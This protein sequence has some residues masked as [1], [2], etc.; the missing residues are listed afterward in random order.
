MCIQDGVQSHSARITSENLRTVEMVFFKMASL[1]FEPY[2]S[3]ESLEQRVRFSPVEFFCWPSNDVADFEGS[4]VIRNCLDLNKF[5][6]AQESDPRHAMQIS[7]SARGLSPL[8][9]ILAM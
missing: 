2:Y 1:L 9:Q 8:I 6:R 7:V 4:W 5:R 3:R